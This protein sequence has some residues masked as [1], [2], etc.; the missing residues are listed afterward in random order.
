MNARKRITFD[1]LDALGVLQ[2]QM[3]QRERDRQ[4]EAA[5]QRRD[6]ARRDADARFLA[7]EFEH[8][9]P[10]QV[11]PRVA[12]PAAAAPD[13][14]LQRRLD[15]VAVM[16]ESLSDGIGLDEWLDTDAQLSW[17]REGIGPDVVRRLRRGEWAVRAQIDLHGLRTEEA[18]DA[19]VEFLNRVQRDGL[20][21]VRIIHGKGLGSVN[22]EPV[23]KG[24]VRRWLVQRDEVLAFVEAPPNDGGGGAVLVLLRIAAARSR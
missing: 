12:P 23:L 7:A 15:E 2:R 14:P 22:R 24:K 1:G 10:L 4:A 9:V 18:R 13:V 11:P 5:Q 21:C 17:H 6:A 16:Q 20:R 3:A 8:V 19:L